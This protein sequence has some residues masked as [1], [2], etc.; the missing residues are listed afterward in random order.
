MNCQTSA[1]WGSAPNLEVRGSFSNISKTRTLLCSRLKFSNLTLAVSVKSQGNYNLRTPNHTVWKP[2][3]HATGSLFLCLYT[4]TPHQPL[5]LIFF[6][7]FIENKKKLFCL[8]AY[9]WNCIVITVCLFALSSLQTFPQTPSLIAFKSMASLQKSFWGPIM[10]PFHFGWT[11]L[12]WVIIRDSSQAEKESSF[13]K[14]I[15][16]KVTSTISIE[17]LCRI[18]TFREKCFFQKLPKVILRKKYFSLLKVK[19][20]AI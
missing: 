3:L 19:C 18:K 4:N 7:T 1:I 13:E 11:P 6:Q 20:S 2:G 9:S 10:Q 15:R 17:S 14:M 8:F 16:L 5:F 12:A